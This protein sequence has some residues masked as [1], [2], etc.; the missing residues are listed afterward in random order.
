MPFLFEKGTEC[1]STVP[2]EQAAGP[3]FR[4]SG[5]PAMRSG[6]P[7]YGGQNITVSRL[8]GGG[9]WG[10]PARFSGNPT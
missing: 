10:P 1:Q 3:G 9:W 6:F 5:N 2:R 7:C 8:F 4:F